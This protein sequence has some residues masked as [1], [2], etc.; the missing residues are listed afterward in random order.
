[1][2]G[3]YS[4]EDGKRLIEIARKAIESE[5]TGEKVEI[6]KEKQFIQTRGVFVTLN[7]KR[8]LRGCIGYPH[9]TLPLIEAVVG[10][11]RSAAFSDPRFSTVKQEELQDI[12]I[13]IS[14]L[15]VPEEVKD[16][17]KIKI[18]RDGLMCSYVSYSGLLLPQVATEHKMSRIQFL[19]AVCQKAG[20]PKDS[21][22][23]PGFKLWKFSAQIFSESQ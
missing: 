4:E 23:K 7:K 1:M 6:P 21:W 3:D 9:A 22:E 20:L 18:G 17:K 12:K 10:A 19:E 11:A 16:V 2:F 5:F 13:E 14:I 15:S 8:K